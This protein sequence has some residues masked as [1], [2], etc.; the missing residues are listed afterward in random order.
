MNIDVI[1]LDSAIHKKI[2]IPLE[3]SSQDMWNS[4]NKDLWIDK[5]FNY[6]LNNCD[7]IFY[8]VHNNIAI[9]H[10]GL[11][12]D[13]VK[14]LYIDPK[15]RGQKLSYQIYEYVF[16]TLGFIKSDDARES[17]A[18]KIWKKLQKK[19]SKLISYDPKTDVF[20]YNSLK[21]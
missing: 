10:L 18:T 13:T 2:Y 17:S 16:L 19:Y 6:R 21:F 15:F 4:R 7:E 3:H 8:L 14:A 12:D 9:G 1:N 20:T 5:E 11:N